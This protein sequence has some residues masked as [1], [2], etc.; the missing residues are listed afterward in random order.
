M[1]PILVKPGSVEN[2]GWK[3]SKS[4]I[5]IYI[6]ICSL[7]HY[8]AGSRDNSTLNCSAK[9]SYLNIETPHLTK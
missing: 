6:Y 5:Y 2:G 1:Q 9:G 8:T 4:F 7:V 3:G